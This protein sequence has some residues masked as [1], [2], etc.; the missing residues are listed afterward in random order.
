MKDMDDDVQR[1]GG[2]CMGVATIDELFKGPWGI[3]ESRRKEIEAGPF[4]TSDRI[5]EGEVASNFL[6]IR[7]NAR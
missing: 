4:G 7:S 6:H 1:F 3:V 5:Y 2:V